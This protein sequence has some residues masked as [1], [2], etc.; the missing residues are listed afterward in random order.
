MS[1]FCVGHWPLALGLALFLFNVHVFLSLCTKLKSKWFKE[2]HIKSDTLNLIEKKV[3]K[4]LKHMD[5]ALRVVCI[6]SE[7]ASEN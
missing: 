7:T 3:W 4:S 1:S 6:S 2:R 5:L